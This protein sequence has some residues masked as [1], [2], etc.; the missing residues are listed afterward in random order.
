MWMSSQVSAGWLVG[1]G[2]VFGRA[3]VCCAGVV[4]SVSWLAG[5]GVVFGR[6]GVCCVDVVPGVSWLVGW[7]RGCVW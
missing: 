2:V 1:C 3:G 6:A 4:P 7:L 5:C